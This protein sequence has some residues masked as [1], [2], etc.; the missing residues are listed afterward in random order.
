MLTCSGRDFKA[1]ASGVE[2]SGDGPP[3]GLRVKGLGEGRQGCMGKQ[4][5]TI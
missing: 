2:V 1:L 3:L 5:G 4:I